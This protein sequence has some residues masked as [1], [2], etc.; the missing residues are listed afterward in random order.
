MC[1]S[2]PSCPGLALF[3]CLIHIGECLIESRRLLH[4]RLGNCLAQL[5]YTDRSILGAGGNH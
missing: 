4:R 1:A 2:E 3:K 5:K